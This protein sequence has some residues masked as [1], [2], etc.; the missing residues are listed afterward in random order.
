[1]LRVKTFGAEK[2]RERLTTLFLT[3]DEYLGWECTAIANHVL[4]GT[5]GYRY[6]SGGEGNFVDVVILSARFVN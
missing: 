5:G 2:Q 6:A 1:M 3:N 4:N